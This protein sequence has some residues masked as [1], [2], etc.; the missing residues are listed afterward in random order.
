MCCALTVLIDM[1][2]GKAEGFSL[3]GHM[4][5]YHKRHGQRRNNR[6]GNVVYHMCA[7]DS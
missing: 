2:N 3:N 4:Q 5:K 6:Q 1:K 7:I